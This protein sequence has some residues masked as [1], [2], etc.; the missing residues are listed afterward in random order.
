[1]NAV[2]LAALVPLVA[3]LAALGLGLRSPRGAGA[4]AAAAKAV[5]AGRAYRWLAELQRRFPGREV[6]SAAHAGAVEL[7]ATSMREA[8][9][10]DVRIGRF[11]VRGEAMANLLGRIPGAT[12]ATAV[13]LAA[14]HDV[15]AGAPGAIDDGGA[16]AAIL[17]AARALAAAARGGTPPPCDVEVAI[18]DGEEWGLLGSK[19]HLDATTPEERARTRAAI[20]VELVGW[21]RD[22]LVLHTIPHGFAW[23]APGV[24]PAWLPAAVIG[25][26][27]EAGVRVRLGDPWL[28]PWYQAT[29]RV[30]GVRTGGDDGAFAERG[31]PA[32]LLSGSSLLNFYE[33][34][35]TER[36][37][38]ALVDPARL[39][40]AA[41]VLAAAAVEI[42]SAD[43]GE[44]R[45]GDPYLV[46]GS[47]GGR[48]IVLGPVALRLVALAALAPVVVA[49]AK[50]PLLWLAALALAALAAQGSVLGILVG[51]P[52]AVGAAF[53]VALDGA[54]ARVAIYAGA[55]PLMVEAL[56]LALG[57]LMFGF[58][59]HGG[60]VETALV[61]LLAISGCAAPTAA[62]RRSP[63]RS[64]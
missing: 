30:M 35:H 48:P 22:R 38:L 11:R 26:A 59:W 58:R 9:I 36:D 2:A 4:A 20:A 31:V 28:S 25:A 42:G 54:W 63:P 13:V 16:V 39:D 62:L 37:D 17:E 32:A 41:R 46:A 44:R 27:G 14:H 15:V 18:F 61:A 29:V 33:G 51:V 34:Y 45:F 21:R 57:G 64:P 1:M 3:L 8:G 24:P 6:G 53:A 5:E 10:E 55:L 40:D 50:A 12:S 49:A 56:V 7:I 52:L 23:D 47:V 19:V 60:A 43:A